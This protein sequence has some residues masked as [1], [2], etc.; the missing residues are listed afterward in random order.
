MKRKKVYYVLTDFLKN[1]FT[2]YHLVKVSIKFT[3]WLC[4]MGFIQKIK[5]KRDEDK[6][7]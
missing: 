5:L 2:C 1:I 3:L 7:V 6:S 4:I